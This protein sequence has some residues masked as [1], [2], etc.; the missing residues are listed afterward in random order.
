MGSLIRDARLEW[1]RRYNIAPHAFAPEL[2]RVQRG[3]ELYVC[4]VDGCG[5]NRS[6]IAHDADLRTAGAA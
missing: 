1:L 6:H 3:R 2:K 5:L 4:G